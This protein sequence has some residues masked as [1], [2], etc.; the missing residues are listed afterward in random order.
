M[1]GWWLGDWHQM[2]ELK[3][4]VGEGGVWKVSGLSEKEHH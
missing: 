3:A 2:P 1:T 4:G